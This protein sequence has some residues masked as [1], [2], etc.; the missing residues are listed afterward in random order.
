MVFEEINTICGFVFQPG[1]PFYL[2]C[3][4]NWF[5]HLMI[6]QCEFSLCGET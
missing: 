2:V 6:C 3:E 1:V 4:D 5:G